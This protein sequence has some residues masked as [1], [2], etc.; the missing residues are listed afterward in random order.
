MILLRG[1]GMFTVT[2]VSGWLAIATIVWGLFFMPTFFGWQMDLA[3]WGWKSLI[4]L[5]REHSNETWVLPVVQTV[6]FAVHGKHLL[7][8][9]FY[10]SL[11]RMII[12]L[13]R[14]A[15]RSALT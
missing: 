6:N 8:M 10:T 7:L 12:T 1:L 5:L 14:L 13:L 9:A 2:F 11:W 4:D 3:D 15:I